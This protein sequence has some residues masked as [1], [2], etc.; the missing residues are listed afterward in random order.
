MSIHFGISSCGSIPPHES[1]APRPRGWRLLRRLVF[2]DEAGVLNNSNHV[3]LAQEP[4]TL[5]FL[6]MGEY[7]LLF[8][9]QPPVERPHAANDPRRL[10]QCQRPFD[11]VPFRQRV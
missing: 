4:A 8:L 2:V 5:E 10:Q 6:G 3:I 11:R 1:L 7:L 9:I